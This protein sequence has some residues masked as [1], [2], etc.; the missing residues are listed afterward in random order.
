MRTIYQ[1]LATLLALKESSVEA[2][3]GLLDA[4][5][6]VPF[7]AR[8]RKELTG[9]L[10]EV[11]I[12][13]VEAGAQKLRTLDERKAS[14]LQSIEDQ[15]KLTPNLRAAIENADDLVTVEDLYAPYRPKRQTRA[16]KAIDA[17]L[18]PLARALMRDE[19]V[20]GDARNYVCDAYPDTE[21]VLAGAR[22]ILA[23]E[24]A[25]VPEARQFVREVLRDHGKL[26]SKRRRGAEID[27]NFEGYYD[28]ISQLSRVK[29]H[30]VLAL[31]R[32]ES[33]KA[34]SSGVEVDD[35]RTTSDLDRRFNRARKNSLQL[36]QV[37]D[38]AYGRLLKP[39]VER[40]VRG[41]L[42]EEADRHA[43]G[44]F[45]LNLRNLLLQA[46]MSGTTVM[47][48]DPGF[49][50][51]CKIAVVGPTGELL[52]TAVVYV[53]DNRA[54]RAPHEIRALAQRHGVQVIAIG[55][56]TASS[57]TQEVVAAAIEGTATKFA[58]VDEAGASV[59]S[60]SDVA[61]DEFPSLDVSFRGAV[62]IGR[63]LQDPLA[64]LV[65]IDP[66][67]IGVGMYQHDVDQ[68]ALEK[69]VEAVVVDAVN[70][71]GVELS[72]ASASL[73]SYVSGIGPVLAKRIVE[74]G[75]EH[76][77]RSRQDLLKV[78]GLGAKAFEQSA[79]FLRIRDGAEPLDAT[80]IHP[81]NYAVA[82]AILK[83]AGVRPGDSTLAAKLA[84][85]R[86][87]GELKRLAEAH[88]VGVYT[89][90]DI[91]D[92][93][94]RPGRD[95][96]GDVPPPELRA[97]QLKFE[98][99]HEGMKLTGTVR[100]VVD[101]GAFIDLGLKEDGLVH[102]SKLA[103]R[104]IKNPHDVVAVGDRVEVTVVQVDTKRR[105]IGLSMID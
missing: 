18:E 2:T 97:G 60:A 56:G 96:R 101:F 7:I 37:I 71:V 91:V 40:D 102:V 83:A 87:S 82:R 99:L 69:A 68:K 104:F 81:E 86:S 66:K 54:Q 98:D 27:P 75:R 41:A 29:P 55:N 33:L 84:Q 61:R 79:G 9:N 42:E 88:G 85:I 3:L 73:L 103:N 46:P 47:A 11:Q 13:A 43:I 28:F 94:L 35:A 67:S 23:E 52:D 25:A 5:N 21:A 70:G 22:D 20:V 26:A 36:R 59:Y 93:L 4:G 62:S 1:R 65:K 12:R 44:V 57:E 32:G 72:T 92:G 49:R 77:F 16:S 58:V 15:G 6:T 8:Y 80:G 105:R 48:V 45:A 19:D 74:Y 63:R 34:L 39:A 30:Q 51:G 89:L 50:T 10:D 76:G 31:R 95:P 14:V 53:H 38:D 100:N 64:E 17:G 24:L 78:K 90:E